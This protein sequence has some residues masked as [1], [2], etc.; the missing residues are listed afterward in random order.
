MSYGMDMTPLMNDPNLTPADFVRGL[1]EH[2][3]QDVRDR[4]S[5][6]G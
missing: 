3:T 6:I 5:R 1:I 4:L 2:F